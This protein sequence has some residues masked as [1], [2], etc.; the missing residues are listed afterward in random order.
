MINY[1]LRII[2]STNGSTTLALES[3][4]M[5]KVSLNI[6]HQEIVTF[7]DLPS[8]VKVFFKS[9]GPF[10]KRITSLNFENRTLSE[11]VVYFDIS[12][13]DKPIQNRLSTENIPIGKM[14]NSME[15]KRVIISHGFKEYDELRNSY[16]PHSILKST[17][18]YKEYTIIRNENCWFHITEIFH[19]KEIVSCIADK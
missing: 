17:Y 10:V 18:P 7:N 2:L 16:L 9:K 19:S 14:L 6:I 4:I 13:I 8:D 11:N 15:N 12:T 3:L 1:C 5:K